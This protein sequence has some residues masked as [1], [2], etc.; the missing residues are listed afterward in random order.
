MWVGPFLSIYWLVSDKISMD[1]RFH[2]WRCSSTQTS[3][4]SSKLSARCVNHVRSCEKDTEVE[5]L[6]YGNSQTIL[7]CR[8]TATIWM[9]PLRKHLRTRPSLHGLQRSPNSRAERRLN[10][11]GYTNLLQP[12]D[13]FHLLTFGFHCRLLAAKRWARDCC[14]VSRIKWGLSATTKKRAIG[15]RKGPTGPQTSQYRFCRAPG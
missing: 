5:R 14:C 6:D 7:L 8:F 9:K 12:R 4:F 2:K 3:H 13:Q 15:K 1:T 11:S 10:P